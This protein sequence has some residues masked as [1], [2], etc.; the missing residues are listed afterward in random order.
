MGMSFTD[1]STG[2][3][4]SFQLI[5]FAQ[6]HIGSAQFHRSAVS[7][8]QFCVNRSHC[9]QR[10]KPKWLFCTFLHKIFSEWEIWLDT[11]LTSVISQESQ[12]CVVHEVFFKGSIICEVLSTWQRELHILFYK[13]YF[14][15]KYKFKNLFSVS[16]SNNLISSGF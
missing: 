14:F 10:K 2:C 11:F 3:S 15:L 9:L 1:I 5:P 16:E 4:C 6:K 12:L 8:V 13:N 7:A